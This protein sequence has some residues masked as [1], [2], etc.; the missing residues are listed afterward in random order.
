M[1]FYALHQA[2]ELFDSY[3]LGKVFEA[4]VPQRLRRIG[5]CMIAL[6]VLRPLTN[7]LL[8]VV[9]TMNNPEGQRIIS[10]GFSID[11][12][13]IAVF[14]GLILAIGHVMADA[15]RIAEHNRQIV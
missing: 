6:S 15:N 4:S 10:L 7:M 3:R 2:Y 8:T 9:L 14:G 12:Y 13:M 11:D 5:L 1:L